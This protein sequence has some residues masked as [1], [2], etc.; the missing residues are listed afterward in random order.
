MMEKGSFHT[1]QKFP[2]SDEKV[3]AIPLPNQLPK[4]IDFT[5]I[6]VAAFKSSVLDSLINQNEDLMARLSIALRK[7][8][9]SEELIARFESEQKA[10]KSR[11]DTL[12]EQ[13]LVLQ[14]KDRINSA[15]T[16]QL[17]EENTT[18]KDQL[19]Q[20]EKHY[21][22]VYV[23]AQ[24]FQRRM[25]RLERYRASVQK[26][27]PGLRL[28]AREILSLKTHIEQQN[29][30]NQNLV[31]TYEA[32]IHDIRNE[33]DSLKIRASE[34]DRYFDE[35]VAVENRLV[36]ERRQ[37]EQTSRE[38]QAE[39]VRLTAET[40]ELRSEVKTRLVERESHVTELIQLRTDC[41]ELKSQNHA[42]TEQVESLQALWSYKQR[43]TESL[44]EKNQ[45]LQ[46]LNQALSQNLNQQRKEIQDLKQELEVDRHQSEEKIKSLLAEIQML[47]S[48]RPQ[49]AE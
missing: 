11:F 23:Q 13:V 21:S 30:Q 19:S 24:A 34:R 46:K 28:R 47:R 6:P 44:D 49:Q 40:S 26:L 43:E 48:E 1:S 27:A 35:M 29:H 18:L 22:E 31:T 20:L 2:S 42:M 15:R 14:E 37:N 16:G 25:I 10:L 8:S 7:T 36:L 38:N 41:A 45:N 3:R 32:K 9:E 12:K 17:I 39:I 33:V 4:G 5:E